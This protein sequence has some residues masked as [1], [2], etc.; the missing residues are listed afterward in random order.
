VGH[1]NCPD[2]QLNLVWAARIPVS[3]RHLLSESFGAFPELQDNNKKYPQYFAGEPVPPMGCTP[4]EEEDD[5]DEDD[6][7]E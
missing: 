2:L 6:D 4:D 5:D 7:N 1:S 3:G